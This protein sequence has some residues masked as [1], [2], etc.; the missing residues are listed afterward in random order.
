MLSA[1]HRGRQ[2]VSLLWASKWSARGLRKATEL[3]FT[4]AV[5]EQP[6]FQELFQPGKRA[7]L[8]GMDPDING[9]VAVLSWQNPALDNSISGSNGSSGAAL[10]PLGSLRQGRKGS[11]ERSSSSGC[12]HSA[13]AGLAVSVHDMPIELW[14]QHKRSKRQ[15][16]PAALLAIL[17]EST[18]AATLVGDAGAAGAGGGDLVVRAVLEHTTPQH[19]SGKYAWYGMG[20]SFGLL[21]GLLTAQG[22]RYQRVDASAWKRHLGLFRLGKDG[23]LSLARQLFPQAEAF[24]RRKK[25]HGRA[26]ALLIAAWGL[27]VRMTAVEQPGGILSYSAPVDGDVSNE[28]SAGGAEG[29]QGHEDN[30]LDSVS[31]GSSTAGSPALG[32]TVSQVSLAKKPRQPR[33][34]FAE[35]GA[36]GALAKEAAPRK[37][38]SR[39]KAAAEPELA[40]T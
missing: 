17:Q 12:T 16:D 9:A 32:E 35:P 7:V 11:A 40:T 2:L 24:L 26:E 8:L 23:S 20:F 38:Q 22:I 1:G 37:R 18:G 29:P 5:S 36:D 30:L 3:H 39:K 4:A 14:E 31:V 6:V 21:Q 28:P 27:G 15:P 10:A 13:T 19:L 34:K 33:K 25:D